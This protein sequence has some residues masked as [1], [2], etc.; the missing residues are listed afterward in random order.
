MQKPTRNSQTLLERC[1]KT[2]KPSRKPK[3]LKKTKENQKNI[4]KNQKN[5][6]VKG[7]RLALGYGFGLFGFLVFPKVFTKPTNPSIKPN[8]PKKTTKPSGKPKKQKNKTISKG[9]S[10]TF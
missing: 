2:K 10:E 8:I 1:N 6:V 9:G 3:I 4:R 5:K 7:F